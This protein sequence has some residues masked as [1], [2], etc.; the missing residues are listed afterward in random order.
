MIGF[1]LLS[2]RKK[3]NTLIELLP[4]RYFLALSVIFMITQF[5]GDG[6]NTVSSQNLTSFLNTTS[7]ICIV[8]C[9]FVFVYHISEGSLSIGWKNSTNFEKSV[10]IIGLSVISLLLITGVK[11]DFSL[12]SLIKPLKV[13][14]IL[15]I[16]LLICNNFRGVKCTSN[17]YIITSFA[18]VF[19]V[20]LVSVCLSVVQVIE[21]WSNYKQATEFYLKEQWSDAK[22]LYELAL[23]GNQ[24]TLIPTLQKLILPQ[25]A[26]VYA[27]VS[28]LDD[29]QQMSQNLMVFQNTAKVDISRF[30]GDFFY[31]TQDWEQAVVKYE[32]VVN[33]NFVDPLTL[34]RLSTIYLHL[35]DVKGIMSLADRYTHIP[36]PDYDGHDHLLFTGNLHHSREN[37]E[38]SAKFFLRA[39]ESYPNNP[40]VSYKVGCALLGLGEYEDALIYFQKTI[41]LNPAFADALYRAGICYEKMGLLA[42]A[43]E[44]YSLTLRLKPTHLNSSERLSILQGHTFTYRLKREDENA[45]GSLW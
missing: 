11:K 30:W 35:G 45:Q 42:R 2:S 41:N 7:L 44:M 43:Q 12:E 4:L 29:A 6:G 13:S 3:Q 23:L 36:I 28:N 1:L 19:G 40:Y 16:W 37:Y 24:A 21:V 32:S 10:L 38:V 8:S 14:G 15:A 5:D 39:Y 34:N 18:G 22:N 17:K 20:F 33:S 25:I 26:E 9:C 31:Y 27:R